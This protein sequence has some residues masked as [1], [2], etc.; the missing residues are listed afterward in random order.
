MYL[1]EGRRA[2][3]EAVSKILE[4]NFPI[5]KCAHAD[6]GPFCD[7]CADELRAEVEFERD[8][9]ER[10][11]SQN[12]YYK[13]RADRYRKALEDAPHDS[14]CLHVFYAYGCDCWKAAALEEKP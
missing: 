9:K 11:V 8:A 12:R 10:A 2:G 13:A 14:Q 3:G 5:Q 1:L 4:G 7:K 6:Y